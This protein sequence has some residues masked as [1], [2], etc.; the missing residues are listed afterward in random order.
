MKI[1]CAAYISALHRNYV[2]RITNFLRRFCRFTKFLI[3]YY[4][5]FTIYEK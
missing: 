5:G 2:W 1:D 3:C 4:F